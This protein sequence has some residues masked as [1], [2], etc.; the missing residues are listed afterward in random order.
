MDVHQA[1][2]ISVD[3][4][5]KTTALR[6]GCDNLTVVIIAFDYFEKFMNSSNPPSLYP[7]KEEKVAE[8]LLPFLKEK[9]DNLGILNDIHELMQ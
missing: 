3:C 9:N 1:C 6:K 2:G 8:V 5:L 7:V 4:I